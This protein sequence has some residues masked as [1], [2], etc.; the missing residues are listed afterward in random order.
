MPQRSPSGPRPARPADDS[1]RSKEELLKELKKLRRLYVN[2]KI[3]EYEH[4]KAR[5]ELKESQDKYRQIVETA[6][7]IIY[8]TDARGY[9]TYANHAAVRIIGYPLKEIIGKNYLE[10]IHPEYR[11]RAMKHYS[12]SR[13]GT[14][15]GVHTMNFPQSERTAPSSGWVRMCS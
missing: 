14:A 7:D 12:A 1:R 4:D 10:L 2:L 5:A 6:N 13:P 3:L 8:R 9:F 15:S 11:K